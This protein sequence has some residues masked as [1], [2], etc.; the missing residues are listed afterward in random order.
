MSH[1][2]KIALGGAVAFAL[3]TGAA[4][5]HASSHAYP[6]AETLAVE[7]V[8][9]DV[10]HHPFIAAPAADRAS[11]PVRRAQPAVAHAVPRPSTA[12][13]TL[14][15]EPTYVTAPVVAH[16]PAHIKAAASPTVRTHP[17]ALAKHEEQITAPTWNAASCDNPDANGSVTIPAVTGVFYT[18][19][20]L[21]APAANYLIGVGVHTVTASVT[22]VEWTFTVADLSAQC[23]ITPLDTTPTAGDAPPIWRQATCEQ[24]NA[25][26][27]IPFVRGVDYSLDGVPGPA[28]NYLLGT[29][30][31]TVTADSGS[32][33]RLPTWT[34][35]ITVP[36]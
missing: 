30:A 16:I 4:S 1:Y 12:L 13:S 19:D 29:G 36:C 34:F 3:V 7:S 14:P 11:Q 23:G 5:A 32:A 20:G 18:L 35:T 26:V 2:R 17:S 33:D 6:Q 31:H 28:G 15:T 22:S 27:D 21:P 25:S 10:Q 9:A 24:P 8:S